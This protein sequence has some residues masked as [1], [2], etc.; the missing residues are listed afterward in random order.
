MAILL[1][2]RD[3]HPVGQRIDVRH[4]HAIRRVQSGEDLHAVA[5]AVSRLELARLQPVALDGER[6]VDAVAVLHGGVRDGHHLFDEGGLEP[7]AGERARLQQRLAIRRER[8]EGERARLCRHRGTDARDGGGETLVR[9]GIDAQRQRLPDL[10]PWRHAFGNLGAQLQRVHAHDGHDRHLRF[11][12]LAERD[13]PLL[14]IAVERRADRRVLEVTLGQFH[15]R[16]RRVDVG[17]EVLRLLQRGIIG[18]RLQAQRRVRVI[19]RLL[20]DELTLVQLGR[21][22]EGLPGLVPVRRR[23]A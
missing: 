13:H 18:G 23:L 14:D 2:D 17:L 20:R 16:R 9:E 10:H 12:Q 4:R 22:L 8:F 3:L 21:A 6:P 15:G 11:H 19:E 7:H 1:L 5:D